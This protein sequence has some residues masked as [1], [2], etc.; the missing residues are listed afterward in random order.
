MKLKIPPALQVLVFALIMWGIHSQT[1]AT[2]LVFEYQQHLSWA[3]FCI[4]VFI[5]IIALY[6]FK[7]AQ[8][9]VDPLQPGKATSLVTNGI[10]KYSRNP[11]YLAMFFVLLAVAFRI[12]NLYTFIVL[13]LY[14]WY[15]TT[16]QIK[17][18]EEVLTALFEDDF[19]EYM[20]TV[21]RWI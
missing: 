11:M 18:E 9:S 14:V 12:G 10:Y 5:G 15:I 8:T 6:S 1:E 17:P 4:G 20:K 2:H 21:R 7:R 19:T 16:Y 3:L 13:P